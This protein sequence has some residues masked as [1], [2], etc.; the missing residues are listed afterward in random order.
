MI[1]LARRS[2][3]RKLG[4]ALL[5]CSRQSL[6]RPARLYSTPSRR[7][8]AQALATAPAPRVE[9][10]AA[11]MSSP[12]ASQKVATGSD[13]VLSDGIHDFLQRRMT[14]TLL[15]PPVPGD[16]SSPANDMIF[17]GSPVQETLTI[18]DACLHD[19]YDI[20]RAQYL[21]DNL[22]NGS[23]SEAVLSPRLYN[24]FL[25]AY[26][27]MARTRDVDNREEWLEKAWLLYDGMESNWEAVAPSHGTY[28]VMMK[29][30]LSKRRMGVTSSL[31]NEKDP[32]YMLQCMMERKINV[33]SV[34]AD[35][36]LTPADAS[37]I[38]QE[39]CR[40]AAE[41][42]LQHVINDLGQAQ[43]IANDPLEGV[44]E[45]MPVKVLKH[46]I[47]TATD[48]P[49]GPI[50]PSTETAEAIKTQEE[51]TPFNIANLRKHLAEVAYAHRLLP[52][53]T[54][55][56]QKLLEASVYDLANERLK[57]ES[58]K[59][60]EV[61]GNEQKLMSAQ[62]Q[63]WMFDWHEKLQRRLTAEIEI[64]IRD[65]ASV[66]PSRKDSNTKMRMGPFLSLL[67]PSKLS[68]ITIL[69]LMRLQGTG[70]VTEGMKTARALLTVGKAIEMEYKAQILKKNNVH[71][72]VMSSF[73]LTA[74]GGAGAGGG[75]GG[76]GGGG[77]GGGGVGRI[78]DSGFFTRRAYEELRE[79]R[80]AASKHFEDSQEWAS[81]WT[82]AIRVRVAS[83]LVDCLMDVATVT[84]TAVN[85][86]TGEEIFEQQPA[87]FQSYEYLRGH[88][89]GVIRLNPVVAERLQKDD[90]RATLHPRHLPM[91]VKPKAWINHDEGGYIYNKNSVMRLK[92]TQEQLTYLR[93]AA[94]AGHMEHVFASLDVLGSTPWVINREIFDVVLQVW[95]SGD[96]FVK[97]PEANYLEPEPVRPENY[98][99][100]QAAK[101]RYLMAWKQWQ[102][103]KANSHSTRCSV[104]Y[105]VEIARSFLADTMYFPHNIDFR[106]RAYPI[107]PHLNHIGDDLSRGLM[108][109]AEKK[110]LGTSGLRWLK[111]HLANL[112]GFDKG[113]FEERVQ[114]VTDHMADIIDSAERPLE[115]NQWWVKAD[116]P[117]QCL[118]ACKELH[119][120][121]ESSDPEGYESNLPVHQDGTCNGLQHY[122]AL[123]GDAM[124][125]RQVNLDI[126]D[127]PSDV[128]THVADMVELKIKQ[129]IETGNKYAEMLQGKVS[130]KVVKQTVM[131]TVY[132]VTFVGAREQIERQLKDRGDIAAHEVW[133]AS[134]Y[135]A[136]CVIA[137]IGDLFSGAKAI[138]TW[139]TVC[140]RLI[141]KSIPKERID[142]AIE[143][144]IRREMKAAEKAEKAW[145]DVDK[146]ITR[147]KQARALPFS[148]LPKEQMTSVV[149]TTPL[150]LP[151]VQPYRKTKRK[152]VMTSIQTVFISDPNAPSEVNTSKQASAF[153]PNFI[154]SL[155]ATHMMLT[156]L[157]CNK[158]GLTFAS[159]HDSYWTHAGSINKMNEII[160][161][162]FIA[163]HES[164][165][166]ERLRQEFLDRYKEYQIPL[167]SLRSQSMLAKVKLSKAD[168]VALG[169]VDAKAAANVAN[170]VE[171]AESDEEVAKAIGALPEEPDAVE[172]HEHAITHP[173]SSL[174]GV[175]TTEKKKGRGR[176]AKVP[177]ESAEV[178]AQKQPEYESRFI[179]LVDIL[180][181]LPK[182]G[183]FDV[184]KIKDS[185]YF[186]S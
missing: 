64:I 15:P 93:H 43:E 153:P 82:H 110:P 6:P 119:H 137:S 32:S 26:L 71:V 142:A 87:F 34:V 130:R 167:I 152:Q 84:R 12:Q 74:A 163:L 98:D 105:K 178:A 184:Q 48:L 9:D 41:L 11:Q 154:H 24:L 18:I 51:V 158:A 104:N 14:Y 38:I 59:L 123:G 124:G 136:K 141:A 129:D 171:E 182:K 145:K 52:D 102:T 127:K 47:P 72:P 138:Q 81:D 139:L 164:N 68:L 89:L 168:L 35:R 10:Y 29:I 31:Y 44:P 180:P 95:N 186:F 132:G 100:D 134:A 66:G 113:S 121:L 135:L 91:L 19:C 112:S 77:I 170:E 148:R 86:R 97:I 107:P 1:P 146:T 156:A 33:V 22:R 42:N 120:A 16:T 3:P 114:F 150:G 80:K 103:N 176:K 8:L 13:S 37:E 162:T 144:N 73:S 60:E 39:L 36:S 2:T 79:W 122:A 108:K 25:E 157:E 88:R 56:R 179:N 166:L 62:L 169:K 133:G 23:S 126:T 54:A 174:S 118:A 159:V 106:G 131:T 173:S 78:N 99:T 151:I 30:W 96:R 85:R 177:T 115:G 7:N 40:E 125:A 185:K 49:E 70:G 147:F 94:Q 155:D 65:E 17:P 50:D 53:D 76:A 172:D 165:V 90:I 20:H 21:F 175:E 27:E 143:E 4:T 5:S 58:E 140:A 46:V 161:E 128:Y 117:W 55:A 92:D 67:K 61:V 160:R 69:E 57:H 75:G 109:F 149:W 45:V 181:T 101:T 111:I 116:D 63:K 183:E 28:A 83:F